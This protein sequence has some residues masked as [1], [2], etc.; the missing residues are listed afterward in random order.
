M[1]LLLVVGHLL[2]AINIFYCGNANATLYCALGVWTGSDG[3]FK[4]NVKEDVKGL[5]FINKLRPVTYQMDTKKLDGFLNNSQSKVRVVA[6]TH[7]STFTDT[8]GTH[9]ITTTTY[10]T[11]AGYT[12]N[13]NID[14]ATPTS[15]IRSGFIAQEVVKAA[16]RMWL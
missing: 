11:I 12:P 3:R 1:Q 13:N 2:L 6:H 10:D 14:F 4:F 5:E 7:T 15:V 9:T 8:T 16:E